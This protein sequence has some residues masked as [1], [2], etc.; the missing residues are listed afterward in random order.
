M[1]KLHIRGGGRTFIHVYRAGPAPKN[2]LHTKISTGTV[3]GT[4]A[5]LAEESTI[6]GSV[7][8]FAWWTPSGRRTWRFDKFVSS[9]KTVMARRDQVPSPELLQ[10]LREAFTHLD[11]P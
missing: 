2:I 11:S 1:V 10:R 8:S 6:T 5:M 3:I 4:G 7:P 9:L